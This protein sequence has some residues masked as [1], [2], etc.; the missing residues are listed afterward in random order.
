MRLMVT[1]GLRSAEPVAAI[2]QSGLAPA[3]H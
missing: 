3:K 1:G 2:V